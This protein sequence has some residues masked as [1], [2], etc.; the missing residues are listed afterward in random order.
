MAGTNGPVSVIVT[1]KDA[2]RKAFGY[3]A[4]V[5]RPQQSVAWASGLFEGLLDGNW[6]KGKKGKVVITLHAGSPKVFKQ[7]FGI[8]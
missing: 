8:N 3:M 7:F 5:S 6:F 4:L 1:K 2:T